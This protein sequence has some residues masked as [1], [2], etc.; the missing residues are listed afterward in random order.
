M[1][2]HVALPAPLIRGGS[3]IFEKILL[4]LVV[5]LVASQECCPRNSLE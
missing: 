3:E 5:V 1:D 4:P 2:L